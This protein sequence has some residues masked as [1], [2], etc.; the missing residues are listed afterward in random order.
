MALKR[1]DKLA[2]IRRPKKIIGTQTI[3]PITSFGRLTVDNSLFS[4]DF[5]IQ[6][7]IIVAKVNQKKYGK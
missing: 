6:E 4:K 2:I 5:D 7:I 3:F 1:T